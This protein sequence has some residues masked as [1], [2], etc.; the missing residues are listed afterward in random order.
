MHVLPT[1]SMSDIDILGMV[2]WGCS[3][4]MLVVHLSRVFGL[5]CLIAFMPPL[6]QV[7]EESSVGTAGQGEE[8]GLFR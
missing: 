4:E 5:L 1:G 3:I 8:E 6:I 7:A 2:N